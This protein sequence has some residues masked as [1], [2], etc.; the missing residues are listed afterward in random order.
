MEG[1]HIFR[2]NENTDVFVGG[3]SF[4]DGA[5][6]QERIDNFSNGRGGLIPRARDACF[7]SSFVRM[8]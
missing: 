7:V 2:R 6:K 5:R 1:G 3:G 4:L 8:Q